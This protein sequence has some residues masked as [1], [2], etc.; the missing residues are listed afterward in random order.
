MLRGGIGKN[1]GRV[2][3]KDSGELYSLSHLCLHLQTF[4]WGA[5]R[6]PALSC[7]QTGPVNQTHKN[8]C[9]CE[10]R[11]IH[12]CISRTWLNCILSAWQL[13]PL[14]YTI[15]PCIYASSLCLLSH[16]ICSFSQMLRAKGLWIP[17]FP[18]TRSFNKDP[19][20]WYFRE[21]MKTIMK[22]L[23]NHFEK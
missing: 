20:Q 3:S 14:T 4:G 5:S 11:L 8:P 16:S 6:E 18:S 21:H 17:R 19:W 7:V 1:N 15:W 10:L 9:S 13:S 12:V 2:A 23:R 22:V